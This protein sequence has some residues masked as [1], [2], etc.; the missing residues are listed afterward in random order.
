MVVDSRLAWF[1]CRLWCQWNVQ[2]S[3][4][5]VTVSY[6]VFFLIFVCIGGRE[7]WTRSHSKKGAFLIYT[8]FMYCMSKRVGFGKS[9]RFSRSEIGC[10]VHSLMG[11]SDALIGQLHLSVQAASC[12][13]EFTTSVCGIERVLKCLVAGIFTCA[14][15]A[16]RISD[17]YECTSSLG[18][19]FW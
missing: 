4:E 8:R 11:T 13:T 12:G 18:C 10:S 16:G 6:V 2:L 3:R 7:S 1:Y 15:L 14:S 5:W 9:P 19:F 17:I